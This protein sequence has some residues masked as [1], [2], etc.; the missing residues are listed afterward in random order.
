MSIPP[1]R[2]RPRRGARVVRGARVSSGAR[3]SESRRERQEHRAVRRRDGGRGDAPAERTRRRPAILRARLP[4]RSGT[5]LTGSSV[6]TRLSPLL[7]LH[8]VPAPVTSALPKGNKPLYKIVVE[9]D[10]KDARRAAHGTSS[11]QHRLLAPSSPPA[12]PRRPDPLHPAAC[13]SRLPPVPSHFLPHRAFSL[14]LSLN[15]GGPP[16]L[17][18]LRVKLETATDGHRQHRRE[19]CLT[20]R[21]LHDPPTQASLLVL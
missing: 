7:P 5:P 8:P 1:F 20:A 18:L 11:R 17:L 21:L 19:C 2:F 4:S 3:T 15:A 6:C 14:K 9:R 10:G 16:L 12:T 13:L